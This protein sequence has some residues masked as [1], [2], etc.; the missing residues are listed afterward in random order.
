MMMVT[1]III[2]MG[3]GC[4]W[5]LSGGAAGGGWGKEGILRGEEDGTTY[6]YHM[7]AA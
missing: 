1:I 2:I 6:T 4:I 5:G 7:I 3:H